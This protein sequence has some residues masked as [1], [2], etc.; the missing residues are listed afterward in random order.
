MGLTRLLALLVILGCGQIAYGQAATYSFE[1]VLNQG[2]FGS[3]PDGAPFIGTFTYGQSQVDVLPE[4][5]FVGHYLGGSVSISIGAGTATTIDPG[6]TKVFDNSPFLSPAGS[7]AFTMDAGSGGVSGTLGGLAIR[8]LIVGL[9]DWDGTVFSSDSLP[10]ATLS[11]AD[12]ESARIIIESTSGSGRDGFITTLSLNP[13]TSE[14]LLSELLGEVIEMN[15][16]AGISNSLDAK[17]NVVMDALDDVNAN[18]DIAAINALDSFIN[19]VEAQ[20][21]NKLTDAEADKLVATA[22]LI[23]TTL[24]G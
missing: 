4:R 9:G 8:R 2:G 11:L 22:Q 23:I 19:A 20:R 12:F 3:L 24:G 15:L 14:S 10:F 17:I 6:D 18:N 16:N 21:G 1:G 7:D 5:P 13:I